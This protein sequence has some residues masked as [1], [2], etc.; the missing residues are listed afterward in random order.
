MGKVQEVAKQHAAQVR[1]NYQRARDQ[2]I[3]KAKSEKMAAQEKVQAENLAQMERITR[4]EIEQ[5]GHGHEMAANYVIN[6][7][8][9]NK[10]SLKRNLL[11]EILF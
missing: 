11:I 8:L 3:H 1:K 5:I 6:L 9:K 4:E 2:E 7:N 10:F